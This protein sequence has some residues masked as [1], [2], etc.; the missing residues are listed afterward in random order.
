[1]FGRVVVVVVVPTPRTKATQSKAKQKLGTAMRPRIVG[2]YLFLVSFVIFSSF[3][4]SASYTFTNVTAAAVAAGPYG[5]VVL[6]SSYSFFFI[7]SSIS[8][9]ACIVES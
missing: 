7:H 4:L 5:V 1:M 3:F 2:L 9:P 6:P 8:L